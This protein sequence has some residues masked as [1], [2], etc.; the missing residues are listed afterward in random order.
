MSNNVSAKAYAIVYAN[1][2]GFGPIENIETSV[3]TS[4][5]EDKL[6]PRERIDVGETVSS[7]KQQHRRVKDFVMERVTPAGCSL[8]TFLF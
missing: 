4:Y 6:H 7:V 1:E 3:T 2:A 5:N 8:T